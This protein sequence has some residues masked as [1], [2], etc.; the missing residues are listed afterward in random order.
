[1]RIQSSKM[2]TFPHCMTTAE[3]LVVFVLSPIPQCLLFSVCLCYFCSYFKKKTV[4][5]LLLRCSGFLFKR[6]IL[7]TCK[8]ISLL[9]QCSYLVL[10]RRALRFLVAKVIHIY[11]ARR[12]FALQC[13]VLAICV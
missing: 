6:K 13:I 10:W 9:C 4:S 1:M 3:Q 5:I 12:A 8:V 2:N 11:F 7:V